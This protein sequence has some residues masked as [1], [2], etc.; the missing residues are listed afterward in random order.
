MAHNKFGPIGAGFVA[1]LLL[2]AGGIAQANASEGD[3]LQAAADAR[4]QK[5]DDVLQRHASNPRYLAVLKAHHRHKLLAMH[6]RSHANA[7]VAAAVRHEP[8]PVVVA[9]NVVAPTPAP[10]SERLR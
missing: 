3:V 5:C 6:K 9:S 8:A 1:G 2:I 4:L 7:A 10:V